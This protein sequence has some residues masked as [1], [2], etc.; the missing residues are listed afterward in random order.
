MAVRTAA[1]LKQAGQALLTDSGPDHQIL[2]SLVLAL[3]ADFVDSIPSLGLTAD[4]ARDAAGALLATLGEFD[5]DARTNTLSL[6]LSAYAPVAPRFYFGLSD[7][8]SPNAAD[9]SIPAPEG[10]AE[11]P[12]FAGKRVAIYR[13]AHDPDISDVRFSD[14]PGVN[15]AA[16]FSRRTARGRPAALSLPSGL[17]YAVWYGPVMTK[18]NAVTL[19]AS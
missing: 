17:S 16:E 5:Y 7:D 9:A 19:A 11:L 14:A 6:D 15:R 10:M 18:A 1:E 13:L 4:Q 2:P 8:D 12:A 3:L